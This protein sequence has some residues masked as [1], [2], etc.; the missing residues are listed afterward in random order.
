VADRIGAAHVALGSDFDGATVPRA[1]GDVA[2]MPKV[3]DALRSDG[4]TEAEIDA[5]AWENWC[6]VLS[7][8]WPE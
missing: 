3:L 1:V 4:F 5:I 7:A 6:R 2:G 8:W